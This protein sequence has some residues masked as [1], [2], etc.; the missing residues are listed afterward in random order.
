MILSHTRPCNAGDS[1]EYDGVLAHMEDQGAA[2]RWVEQVPPRPQTCHTL[3]PG[4]CD[5]VPVLP[6]N[7]VQTFQN[8]SKHFDNKGRTACFGRRGDS[9]GTLATA[10]L[11][12]T[13]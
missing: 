6:K 12:G 4:K 5:L 11:G 8:H 1:P 13:W 7:V 2:A 10:Q 3:T 9:R